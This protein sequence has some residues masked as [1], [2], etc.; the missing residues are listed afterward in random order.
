MVF[1]AVDVGHG[2]GF[3][4]AGGGGQLTFWG[5]RGGERRYSLRMSARVS[6]KAV[7]S[8]GIGIAR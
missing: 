8:L 2:E 4:G 7:G 5:E 1:V 3:V 6:V